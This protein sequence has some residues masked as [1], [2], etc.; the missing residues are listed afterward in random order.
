MRVAASLLLMFTVA[1]IAWGQR[2]GGSRIQSQEF[3]TGI[4][5]L[6]AGKADDWPLTTREGETL[7]LL[8][9]L[10]ELRFD[11]RVGGD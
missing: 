3:F 9:H 5:I 6:T 8:R 2:H 7:I 4:S 11:R 10:A 1:S